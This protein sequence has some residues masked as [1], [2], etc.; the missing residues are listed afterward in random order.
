M[1][2]PRLVAQPFSSFG[3]VSHTLFIEQSFKLCMFRAVSLHKGQPMAINEK[4]LTKGELR[5]LNALRKSLGNKIADKAFTDW[6][7]TQATEA[8]AKDE[9]AEMIEAALAS[10]ANNKKFNLGRRGY[11]ITK[12]K[13][14]N[15]K[16]I[17][18]VRNA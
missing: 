4:T 8:V 17:K 15:A 3:W 18:A 14:R 10:L 16:G 5:K 2:A 9:V 11:T 13:G 1:F 7:K 12:A 6:K